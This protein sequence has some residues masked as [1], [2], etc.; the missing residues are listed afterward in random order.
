MQRSDARV[1]A[2]GNARDTNKIRAQELRSDQPDCTIRWLQNLLA[3]VC[4]GACV[5]TSVFWVL[6]YF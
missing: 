3:Y 4:V 6:V 2:C 5:D 1:Y